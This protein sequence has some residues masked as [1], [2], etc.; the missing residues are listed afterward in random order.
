[1]TNRDYLRGLND[2]K[3]SKFIG[4]HSEICNYME[5]CSGSC[6]E[7]VKRW[8]ETERKSNVEKGQIRQAD[9]GKCYL[10]LMVADTECLIITEKGGIYRM[11]KSVV[12]TWVIRNDISIDELAERIFNNL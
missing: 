5:H 2:E 12:D 1:M 7:C 6:S 4:N 9:S 11:L 3:L 10:I 8:L